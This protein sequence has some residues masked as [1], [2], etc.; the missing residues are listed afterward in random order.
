VYKEKLVSLSVSWW[1][2]SGLP[3]PNFRNQE[4]IRRLFLENQEKNQEVFFNEAETIRRFFQK[5]W[6]NIRRFFEIRLNKRTLDSFLLEKQNCHG[7]KLLYLISVKRVMGIIVSQMKQRKDRSNHECLKI[8]E[9]TI[10]RQQ[11]SKKPMSAHLSILRVTKSWVHH[12]GRRNSEKPVRK[13]LKKYGPDR[14]RMTWDFRVLY[15]LHVN[16][17]RRTF[18]VYSFEMTPPD[19]IVKMPLPSP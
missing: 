19:L 6:R 16:S 10:L 8:L 2:Q 15:L 13:M 9:V 18:E 5:I 4:L 3:N 11:I 12:S 1:C 14:A 7:Y 17:H